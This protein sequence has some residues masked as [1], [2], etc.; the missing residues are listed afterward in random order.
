MGGG[1]RPS[2]VGDLRRLGGPA[3]RLDLGGRHGAQIFS[4][5]A[6]AALQPAPITAVS[7]R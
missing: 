3:H 5:M 7:N 4:L 1:V 2:G 6:M